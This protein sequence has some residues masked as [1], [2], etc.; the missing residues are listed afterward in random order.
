[1]EAYIGKSTVIKKII[2]KA[3][4]AKSWLH[5]NHDFYISDFIL[6]DLSFVYMT[7]LGTMT[8]NCSYILQS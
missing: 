6:N 7:I 2:N 8:S 3:Y 4:E 5:K 1:M